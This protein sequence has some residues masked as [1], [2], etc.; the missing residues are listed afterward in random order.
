MTKDAYGILLL[1]RLHPLR[2]RVAGNIERI[3]RGNPDKLVMVDEA[4]VDFAGDGVTAL[5]LLEDYD[6]LLIIGTV[7]LFWNEG[8]AVKMSDTIGEV[9][10]AVTELADISRLDPAFDGKLVYATGP[11]ETGDMLIDALTGVSVNAVTLARSVEYYQWEETSRSEKRKLAGG[12]EET[13]TTYS[14][15]RKW[16]DEPIDSSRFENISGHENSTAARFEDETLTAPQVSFGAYE[17]PDFMKRSIGRDE[18]VTLDVTQEQLDALG[19]QI[20]GEAQYIGQS[21]SSTIYIG[22]SAS[23][24]PQEMD[25]R[26]ESE[27]QQEAK[28]PPKRRRGQTAGYRET[29]LRRNEMKTR[30]C[31]YISYDVHAKIAKLVRA[32]VSAGNEISVGGYIDTVL[33]EHMQ[34]NR[35]EINEVYRQGQGDLL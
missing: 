21:T 14:Y 1:F 13:V 22:Q 15:E 4:Y 5:P 28:E 29:F 34:S 26:T 23:G 18:T 25:E 20:E 10:G 9:R 6:N 35:D 24:P 16:V 12:G 31:V 2:N 33:N 7:L 11:A 17:I 30:Q 8:R 3:L 19:A 27:P 32:L